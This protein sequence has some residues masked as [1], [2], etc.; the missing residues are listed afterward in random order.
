M[1]N[2]RPVMIIGVIDPALV[3]GEFMGVIKGSEDTVG[4]KHGY[5]DQKAYKSLSVRSQATFSHNRNVI[6]DLFTAYTKWKGRQGD[7]DAADR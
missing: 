6:Y 4:T 7:Y 3:F 1:A 5:L 2:A